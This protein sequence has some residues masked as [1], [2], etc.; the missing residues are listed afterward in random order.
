MASKAFAGLATLLIPVVGIF[1]GRAILGNFSQH[2]WLYLPIFW[3]LPMSLVPAIMIWSGALK[4]KREEKFDVNFDVHA[5]GGPGHPLRF[6]PPFVYYDIRDGEAI[7]HS[8]HHRLR[9]PTV[10]H[11]WC[12]CKKC[13]Y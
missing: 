10:D 5:A 13:C 3:I 11:P 12:G 9:Y 2:L 7:H 6:H 4:N 1:V 8:T